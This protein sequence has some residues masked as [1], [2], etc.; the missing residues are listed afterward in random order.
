[1]VKDLEPVEPTEEKPEE[2]EMPSVNNTCETEA[3][4][5]LDLDSAV[6]SVHAESA[7]PALDAVETDEADE[8][9]EAD[10]A[11]AIEENR[12]KPQLLATK[13]LCPKC[14]I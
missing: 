13:H 11:D 6:Q 3:S 10:E 5:E 9:E 4:V 7:A 1:M 8:A 12:H 2:T 14:A